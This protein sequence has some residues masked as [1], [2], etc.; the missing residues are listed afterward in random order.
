MATRLELSAELHNFLG[1][2]NVY[3]QPPASVHMNYPAI[4]YS[5]DD[6]NLIRADNKNYNKPKSYLV[7]I[8]HKDPDNTL[9]DDI[10]DVFE[11]ISFERHYKADNLNHYVYKLYY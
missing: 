8:I 9:K 10:L 7:T 5:L 11:H 4:R 3:F 6:I 1:S 2:D